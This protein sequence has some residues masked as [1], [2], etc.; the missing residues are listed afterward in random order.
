V[1]M[2]H[3]E[4]GWRWILNGLLGW[5]SGLAWEILFFRYKRVRV[6]YCGVA[7]G[8]FLFFFRSSWVVSARVVLIDSCPGVLT[9]IKF[10]GFLTLG[11]PVLFLL[12]QP[13]MGRS[14]AI[15]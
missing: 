4:R 6:V 1:V 10:A 8:F 3:L 13:I 11:F 9:I 5:C 2:C 12:L 7:R 15:N 14:H